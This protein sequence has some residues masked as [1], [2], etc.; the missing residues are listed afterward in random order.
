LGHWFCLQLAGTFG[1]RLEYFDRNTHTSRKIRATNRN[2]KRAPTEE[3]SKL[4]AQITGSRSRVFAPRCVG[5]R[6]A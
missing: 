4:T 3:F 1:N 6:S 5:W 2:K